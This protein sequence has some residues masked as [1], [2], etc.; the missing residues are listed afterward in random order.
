MDK[1]GLPY[2]QK[3]EAFRRMAFNV[4][5]RNCDDH[6]KNISFR[7]KAN[8]T[9]AL[10]PA[11]DI[12]FAHNPAGEWTNQHLM[13]VNG[14]FRNFSEDDLLAEGDRFKIGTAPKVIRKVREAIRNWPEFARETSVPAAEIGNIGGQHLLLA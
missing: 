9:W 12:T 5:A 6:T 14:K 11:Y 1:L 8:E 2:E 7:L 3:E 4:M 13:S 10:A